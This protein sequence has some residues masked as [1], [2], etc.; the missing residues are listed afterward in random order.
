MGGSCPHSAE[1][2]PR[3]TVFMERFRG[4]ETRKLLS[5]TRNPQPSS[6]GSTTGAAL[7][8]EE[9]FLFALNLPL[10]SKKPCALLLDPGSGHK[11]PQRC[12]PAQEEEE[13]RD[14]VPQRAF[15]CPALPWNSPQGCHLRACP[16][17][18]VMAIKV[19]CLRPDTPLR[20]RFA[21]TTQGS[22][23]AH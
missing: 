8:F 19:A 21:D 11:V 12:L 6:F 15:S 3:W 23:F 17:A 7:Y 22:L 14:Q 13:E 5:F 16:Y 4:G 18:K 10:T 2:T 9:S 1:T 20:V